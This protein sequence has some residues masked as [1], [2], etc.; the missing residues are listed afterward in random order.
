V[1]QAAAVLELAVRT[2][3]A[4]GAVAED[5]ETI[6]VADLIPEAVLSSESLESLPWQ[7]VPLEEPK[8]GIG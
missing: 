3:P 8:A 6:V 2:W 1:A 4:E 7:K 5:T